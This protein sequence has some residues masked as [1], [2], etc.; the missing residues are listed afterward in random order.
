M[1]VETSCRLGMRLFK[2]SLCFNLRTFSSLAIRNTAVEVQTCMMIRNVC[3]AERAVYLADANKNADVQHQ[4]FY[5]HFSTNWFSESD[6][7][8]LAY[9]PT[10]YELLFPCGLQK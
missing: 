5:S 1:Q 6:H 9:V 7:E 8:N 4:Q 3:T 2:N 10:K